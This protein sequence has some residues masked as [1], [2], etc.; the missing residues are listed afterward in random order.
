MPFSAE[1]RVPVDGSCLKHLAQCVGLRDAVQGATEWEGE[2][3]IHILPLLLLEDVYGDSYEQS[4]KDLVLWNGVNASSQLLAEQD[5]LSPEIVG[6]I[7]RW[8]LPFLRW[9][10]FISTATGEGC[11]IYYDH[12][13]GDTPYEYVWWLSAP[14]SPGEDCETFG[15][16]S[17]GGS[18]ESEWERE[19][20]RFADGRVE[21]S[22]S[23]ESGESPLYL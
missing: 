19:V 12:E 13:R 20:V 4:E 16:A 9:L 21:V 3:R 11:S 18:D 22:E 15:F 5:F 23:G 2:L 1:L 7:G 10:K 17:Y 8:N 6:Y 14:N